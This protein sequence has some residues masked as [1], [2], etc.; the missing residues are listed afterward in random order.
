M[1]GWTPGTPQPASHEVARTELLLGELPEEEEAAAEARKGRSFELLQ[2][3]ALPCVRLSMVT[4]A[5]F[6]L[7][8]AAFATECIY[9]YSPRRRDWRTV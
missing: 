6:F 3:R 5:A 9:L 7:K 2:S 8:R 4:A 1:H